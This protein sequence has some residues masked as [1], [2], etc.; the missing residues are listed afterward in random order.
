MAQ[1]LPKVVASRLGYQKFWSWP[2][3]EFVILRKPHPF[4]PRSPMGP[5]YGFGLIPA[6]KQA[7][8]VCTEH[9]YIVAGA[10]T[11]A[12]HWGSTEVHDAS[13]SSVDQMWAGWRPLSVG[14]TGFSFFTPYR[15]WNEKLLKS[16]MQAVERPAMLRTLALILVYRDSA[17]EE[18][19]MFSSC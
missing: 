5:L 1:P 14:Q 19:G 15:R 10:G 13:N 16:R 17:S 4:L 2:R 7:C 11:S 9:L 6:H 12:E 18:H 3:G 8:G